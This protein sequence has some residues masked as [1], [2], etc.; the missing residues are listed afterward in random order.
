MTL[1]VTPV[2]NIMTKEPCG[3]P[4]GSFRAAGKGGRSVFLPFPG[5][6]GSTLSNRLNRAGSGAGTAIHAAVRVDLVMGVTHGDGA[7]RAF[8]FTGAAS[9]AIIRNNVS[10]NLPPNIQGLP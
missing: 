8:R 4:Q 2:P 6:L 10:H 5:T 3:F 1:Q 7:N 9:D